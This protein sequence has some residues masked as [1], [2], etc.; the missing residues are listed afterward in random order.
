MDLE[1]QMEFAILKHAN[2]HA[3]YVNFRNWLGE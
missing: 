2:G 1:S 3:R